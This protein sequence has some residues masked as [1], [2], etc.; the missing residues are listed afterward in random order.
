MFDYVLITYAGEEINM[1]ACYRFQSPH[2]DLDL[3][4]YGDNVPFAVGSNQAIRKLEDAPFI[5]PE[6]NTLTLTH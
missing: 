1:D 4:P 6:E 2:D 5:P 3:D